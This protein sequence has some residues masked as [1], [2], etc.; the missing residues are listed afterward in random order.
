MGSHCSCPARLSN[1]ARLPGI[2]SR[3][4]LKSQFSFPTSQSTFR[5]SD[6]PI[7]QRC[8][9]FNAYLQDEDVRV[10]VF[11]EGDEVS[12]SGERPYCTQAGRPSLRRNKWLLLGIADEHD[13]GVGVAADECELAAVE[14]PVEVK[15]LLR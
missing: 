13:V 9:S 4:I 11:P 1:W 6:Q 15:Y 8:T 10:G 5:I 7:G 3:T 2:V 14:G 12:V